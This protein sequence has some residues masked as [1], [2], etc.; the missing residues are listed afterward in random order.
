VKVDA[1]AN[2]REYIR[3]ALGRAES[4]FAD[5]DLLL[6]KKGAPDILLPSCTSA[7]SPDGTVVP[8]DEDIRARIVHLQES[9]SSCGQRVLLLARKVLK[10]GGGDIPEAMGVD[11]AMFGDKMMEIAMKGLTVVGLVGIVVALFC[12][13]G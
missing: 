2:N 10:A 4:E 11:H 9:W 7:L 13:M 1:G 8:L 6:L 12:R 3:T 5:E